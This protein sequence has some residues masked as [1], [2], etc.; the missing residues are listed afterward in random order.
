M[1]G[2]NY[3]WHYWQNYEDD[4]SYLRPFRYNP[5]REQ[6]VHSSN[7]IP[8]LLPQHDANIQQ[9]GQPYLYN[10]NRHLRNDANEVQNRLGH[11]N[12]SYDR[13]NIPQ[14]IN[15]SY[16]NTNQ[17]NYDRPNYYSGYYY[18]ETYRRPYKRRP[19][20]GQGVRTFT[21][22]N[23][24][25]EQNR[26]S[27]STETSNGNEE[28]VG[29][30][31]SDNLKN[32][33]NNNNTQLEETL[34]TEKNKST[35]QLTE[36]VCSSNNELINSAVAI[37]STNDI[38]ETTQGLDNTTITDM[39]IDSDAETV[40]I[41]K[42]KA[43]KENNEISIDCINT[44]SSFMSYKC[45]KDDEGNTI[46][47]RTVIKK[48]LSDFDVDDGTD[49]VV[50]DE[51]DE[52]NGY[53]N[54]NAS[55]KRK[56]SESD[57]HVNT[58][59]PRLDNKIKEEDTAE[60]PENNLCKEKE[61]Y[62]KR[63]S[64]K[65]SIGSPAGKTISEQ[66][67][68]SNDVINTP[69]ERILG[70][71][72]KE[73][74]VK[75]KSFANEMLHKAIDV[76]VAPK[77]NKVLTQMVKISHIDA[78]SNDDNVK[79]NS[80]EAHSSCS[81]KR[82]MIECSKA[83]VS[84]EEKETK[85]EV[86]A[87]QLH[88]PIIDKIL[89]TENRRKSISLETNNFGEKKLHREDIKNSSEKTVNASKKTF[90]DRADFTK[91]CI[92]KKTS[93]DSSEQKNMNSKQQNSIP[94]KKLGLRHSIK[95]TDEKVHNIDSKL[96]PPVSKSLPKQDIER[97]TNSTPKKC[98]RQE[99][100]KSESLNVQK[101]N[102]N[103]SGSVSKIVDDHS[104][105]LK[106]EKTNLNEKVLEHATDV[107]LCTS[108][109]SNKENVNRTG[110]IEDCQ[111]TNLNEKTPQ[112]SSI[113]KKINQTVS[114]RR[115]SRLESICDAKVSSNR[116]CSLPSKLSEKE[117]RISYQRANSQDT[118]QIATDALQ[119]Y[120]PKKLPKANRS[121][122]QSAEFHE[123]NSNSNEK[124]THASNVQQSCTTKNPN[125]KGKSSELVAAFH[126][127]KLNLV[128]KDSYVTT[129]NQQ[130]PTDLKKP[131]KDE[132]DNCHSLKVP[133]KQIDFNERDSSNKDLQSCTKKLCKENVRKHIPTELSKQTS[134]DED[135]SAIVTCQNKNINENE[136]SALKDKDIEL[137]KPSEVKQKSR[138]S[139]RMRR[140]TICCDLPLLA[141]FKENKSKKQ[142][143]KKPGRRLT[144]SKSADSLYLPM[145]ITRALSQELGFMK[146]SELPPDYSERGVSVRNHHNKKKQR[147]EETDEDSDV[148]SISYRSSSPEAKRVR[149]NKHIKDTDLPRIIPTVSVS[150][151]RDPRLEKKYRSCSTSNQT[152]EP[153]ESA[154]CSSN[155]P[156]PTLLGP[157][158]NAVCD[159]KSHSNCNLP[160][161]ERKCLMRQKDFLANVQ[162]EASEK[163]KATLMEELL[164]SKKTI[165]E[166][167]NKQNESDYKKSIP[168]K[169]LLILVKSAT[170]EHRTSTNEEQEQRTKSINKQRRISETQTSE[171]QASTE[172][173]KEMSETRQPTITTIDNKSDIYSNSSNNVDKQHETHVI[174]PQS[175][176]D[177]NARKLTGRRLSLTKSN[178][179]KLNRRHSINENEKNQN[180]TVSVNKSADVHNS[181]VGNKKMEEK[182][183]S[184]S[185]PN[186]DK[187]T[188]FE[189]YSDKNNINGKRTCS[190][191]N[192][193]SSKTKMKKG[194]QQTSNK[195]CT[196]KLI[197]EKQSEINAN[198]DKSDE[199]Y[200]NSMFLNVTN[201]KNENFL[202]HINETS[203]STVTEK[204]RTSTVIEIPQETIGN[205][206]I[207]LLEPKTAH[208][209]LH[210]E[211]TILQEAEVVKL[212]IMEASTTRKVKQTKTSDIID[213]TIDDEGENETEMLKNVESINILTL[214]VFSNNKSETSNV[215]Q[216]PDPPENCDDT[217][218]PIQLSIPA[219]T[220][221]K[222]TNVEDII[223]SVEIIE[224]PLPQDQNVATVPTP[225][226]DDVLNSNNISEQTNESVSHCK[227]DQVPLDRPAVHQNMGSFTLEHQ[228]PTCI[229]PVM[230]QN[231]IT[232]DVSLSKNQV[233]A[234][235]TVNVSQMPVTRNC[236]QSM[237]A[238]QPNV[239]MDKRTPPQQIMYNQHVGTESSTLVELL[240]SGNNVPLTTENA[241][242]DIPSVPPNTFLGINQSINTNVCRPAN[243][244]TIIGSYNNQFVG[245]RNR[246]S[247]RALDY[248]KFVDE[249]G[250]S[251]LLYIKTNMCVNKH[252]SE[253]QRFALVEEG[254]RDTLLSI[255]SA[256][257]VIRNILADRFVK[258]FT[259]EQIMDVNSKMLFYY[260]DEHFYK[261]TKLRV[262][263]LHIIRC[264]LSISSTMRHRYPTFIAVN[265]F[266]ASTNQLFS[267]MLQ[268]MEYQRT[269]RNPSQHCPSNI[270]SMNGM[271]Q[272]SGKR[273]T[274]LMT[275]IQ[276]SIFYKQCEYY[277]LFH[278]SIENELRKTQQ[279]QPMMQINVNQQRQPT[280]QQCVTQV[281]NQSL[282]MQHLSSG[283]VELNATGQRIC[284]QNNTNH[285]SSNTLLPLQSLQQQVNNV[286][287]QH[288]DNV[289]RKSCDNTSSNTPCV[290][291]VNINSLA[292]EQT[293]NRVIIQNFVQQQNTLNH[294]VNISPNGPS[295]QQQQNTQNR[296][297]APIFNPPTENQNIPNTETHLQPSSQ[298]SVTSAHHFT[299]PNDNFR[300][301][302]P[303]Y[304]SPNTTVTTEPS[305]NQQS[306][307]PSNESSSGECATS[308]VNENSLKDN[309]SVKDS[310]NDNQDKKT[311]IDTISV[312][313]NNSEDEIIDVDQWFINRMSSEEIIDL[314]NYID[315]SDMKAEEDFIGSSIKTDNQNEVDYLL[316]QNQ[317]TLSDPIPRN[318]SVDSG[319]G[320]PPRQI[321]NWPLHQDL[322]LRTRK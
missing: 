70:K 259:T 104:H 194:V 105:N 195:E 143:I 89:T 145:R 229:N 319:V 226:S 257:V 137:K 157:C 167:K 178:T 24:N 114:R 317:Q 246:P 115:S 243:N 213:L 131:K 31:Y 124:V 256:P 146:V 311:N 237:G 10:D 280:S 305:T 245:S 315:L 214:S 265:S 112:S 6:D 132:Q 286:R 235:S 172:N 287:L 321:N 295:L 223:T 60:I 298:R 310:N 73:K 297:F 42:E 251:M 171:I 7:T 314:D 22:F 166:K 128:E 306:T 41:D 93:R 122:N 282:A 27:S 94:L 165:S 25:A 3:Y 272:Q 20:G 185:K 154:A 75:R 193:N 8:P 300:V 254:F 307:L 17:Y 108:K 91:Y 56:N 88:Q 74:E 158:K 164:G 308:V 46:T 184:T 28:A 142:E 153:S 247:Y 205:L 217:S 162:G 294:D 97:T 40:W 81:S 181:S 119:S 242:R 320:S 219:T 134:F 26:Q 80:K 54:K 99:R 29:K 202:V 155:L 196:T 301:R 130:S 239:A 264:L 192:A 222:E 102:S 278:Q 77:E 173:I 98:N 293:T 262:N 65:G 187:W 141:D 269:D 113:S 271:A 232:P 291:N 218:K 201:E 135:I 39:D 234:S 118:S 255:L 261:L 281:R 84:T 148:S 100:R 103:S 179:D 12:Y 170:T 48:I 35:H 296:I 52:T 66:R 83:L 318:P 127:E 51:C 268:Q 126:K 188:K 62:Q 284:S 116:R 37:T 190:T 299:Y 9:M 276:K 292:E 288:M 225:T 215:V 111:K 208:Q 203:G 204:L 152:K 32:T 140:K 11:N 313:T 21:S 159:K 322:C 86:S 238:L 186:L 209:S 302:L 273:T 49:Y 270:R 96:Q 87:T 275:S 198:S 63:E 228:T 258:Y 304:T 206:E 249:L 163:K 55:T 68:I 72:D 38:T 149:M 176:S 151:V 79:E 303:K 5:L 252:Y 117:D 224:S 212:T 211:T 138:S 200:N 101:D 177:D 189:N 82:D 123:E 285:T 53:I 289:N 160:S 236:I 180:S 129:E 267:E 125:T 18:P 274:N 279:L 266:Y 43:D 59:I 19:A 309:Q 182:K 45:E 23:S 78:S 216:K 1:G 231:I 210:T 13:S 139:I 109:K 67:K 290:P 71:N 47:K 147:I 316:S 150:T 260:L 136:K 57:V 191:D 133:K 174:V 34:S 156:H 76:S 15:E 197:E 4:N 64:S 183:Q 263:G 169:P 44:R 161:K 85:N 241:G 227:N 33:S 283:S 250:T 244:P 69:L 61:E 199:H 248:K 58:K 14:L 253:C 95:T 110:S 106:N 30:D 50:I 168:W 144:R 233:P 230:Q 120:T 277:R 175:C 240:H 121:K 312:N 220:A 36:A 90:Q 221:N 92:P 2:G 207:N 107:Q 16:H